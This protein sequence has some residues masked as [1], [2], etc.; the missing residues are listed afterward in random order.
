MTVQAHFA[1]VLFAVYKLKLL[2]RS[3]NLIEVLCQCECERIILISDQ[4][5]LLSLSSETESTDWATDTDTQALRHLTRSPRALA[6]GFGYLNIW[7][8]VERGLEPAGDQLVS[9]AAVASSAQP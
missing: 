2:A 8:R 9:S 7:G 4:R 3:K 6:T 5:V 1:A